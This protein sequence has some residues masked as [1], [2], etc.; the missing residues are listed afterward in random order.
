MSSADGAA[1]LDASPGVRRTESGVLR[2]SWPSASETAV[3]AAPLEAAESPPLSERV[4][5][6]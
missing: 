3:V 5:S 2:G 6:E 1:D 4:V